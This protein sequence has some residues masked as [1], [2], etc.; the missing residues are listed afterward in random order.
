MRFIPNSFCLFL[1][2]Y[3]FSVLV[4]HLGLDNLTSAFGLLTFFRGI[5][6]IVGPP[7]AGFVFDATQ[8][9]DISF[10][11]AGG[12][13][14]VASLISFGAQIVQKTRQSATENQSSVKPEDI[15]EDEDI[16]E[17]NISTK[18]NGDKKRKTSQSSFMNVYTRVRKTSLLRNTSGV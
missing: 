14:I 8:S 3:C 18:S 16:E 12:S 4:D 13:L 11:M 15:S 17:T 9:Y 1:Q 2:C 10:F 7:L 5:T 6:S